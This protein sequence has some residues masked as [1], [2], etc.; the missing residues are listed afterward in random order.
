MGGFFIANVH[1][2]L[3]SDAQGKVFKEQRESLLTASSGHAAS[4]ERSSTLTP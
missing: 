2:W 4:K 1:S 3:S